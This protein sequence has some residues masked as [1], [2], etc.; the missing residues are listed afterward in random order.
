MRNA[1]LD[2]DGGRSEARDVHTRS[3]DVDYIRLCETRIARV[4]SVPIH[5][6]SDAANSVVMLCLRQNLPHRLDEHSFRS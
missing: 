3:R 6:L 4:H 5:A 2:D 1:L